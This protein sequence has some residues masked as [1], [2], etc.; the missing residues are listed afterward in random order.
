MEHVGVSVNSGGSVHYGCILHSVNDRVDGH[1]IS[2]DLLARVL[3]DLK[4]DTSQLIDDL[5]SAYQ[6]DLLHLVYGTLPSTKDPPR[7]PSFVRLF[8][9]VTC[10]C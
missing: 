1:N 8:F 2:L 6:R 10:C 9:L 7:Q 3:A 5:I 4:Q